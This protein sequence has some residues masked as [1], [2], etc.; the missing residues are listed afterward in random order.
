MDPNEKSLD[1]FNPK[2]GWI[3]ANLTELFH[4]HRVYELKRKRIQSIVSKKTKLRKVLMKYSKRECD[5]V[6][7]FC[8]KLSTQLS[9]MFKG[10]VYGFEKL[11]K[12][13]MIYS[14]MSYKAKTIILN[15]KNSSKKSSRRGKINALK[16]A[17]YECKTCGLSINRQMNAA[18]N[19]YLQMKSL[20]PSSKL[21]KELMK[22]WSGS[23]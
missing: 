17:T 21:F 3:R 12:K 7:D 20:S 23:S 9:R 19:L 16:E 10:Y 22:D 14:L 15:P 11:E 18:I 6:K 8:H 5:R 1:G 4:I 2:I 13:K